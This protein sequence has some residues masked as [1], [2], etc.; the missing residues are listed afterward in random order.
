M[1][2][3]LEIRDQ[4]Q[5]DQ[6]RGYW[7]DAAYKGEA[8]LQNLLDAL[9]LCI[10]RGKSR[11]NLFPIPPE[12]TCTSGPVVLHLPIRNQPLARVNT[13]TWQ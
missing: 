5:E 6:L 8:L 2:F 9:Q 11:A 12:T 10:S 3:E 4:R 7:D 1:E 13:Y